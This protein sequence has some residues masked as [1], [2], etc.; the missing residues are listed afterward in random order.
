VEAGI[1]ENKKK[2]GKMQYEKA[3]V[4]I[5]LFRFRGSLIRIQ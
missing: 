5:T 2:L 4:L 1:W 3:R